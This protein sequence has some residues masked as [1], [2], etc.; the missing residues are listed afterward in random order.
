MRIEKYSFAVI[1]YTNNTNMGFHE[2]SFLIQKL[3]S[4][5]LF[6]L[7]HGKSYITFSLK[8]IQNVKSTNSF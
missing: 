8:G 3:A 1:Q 7:I 6:I 2:T 5:R 4:F